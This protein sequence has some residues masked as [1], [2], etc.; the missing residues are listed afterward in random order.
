M[1]QARN[2]T[3]PR[4]AAALLAVVALAAAA[5]PVALGCAQVSVVAGANLTPTLNPDGSFARF[6]VS[7]PRMH[8]LSRSCMCVLEDRM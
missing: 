7:W 3:R 1:A 6:A 5:A 2:L 8:A 4:V